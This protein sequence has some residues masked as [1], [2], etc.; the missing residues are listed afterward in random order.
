MII[1]RLASIASVAVVFALAGCG[2]GPTLA[3]VEGTLKLNGVPLDKIQVEFWPVGSAPRSMGTTDAQGRYT[4]LTD[5]GKRKGAVLGE[6]KIV[7]KD[8][9]VLGD[10]FLGRAGE[11]VDMTQGKKAQISNAYSD[12]Q[13]SPISKQVTAGKCVIDIDLTSR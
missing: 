9:G 8:V 5:D 3:E 2:G 13:K 12:P 1:H 11:D 4:L 7:L 10:K 6:H